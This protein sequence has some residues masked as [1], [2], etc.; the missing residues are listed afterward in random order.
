[1][2]HCACIE[3]LDVLLLES[4][5][6]CVWKITNALQA[7]EGVRLYAQTI[8]C[9]MLCETVTQLRND[10]ISAFRS[11]IALSFNFRRRQSVTL[12][13]EILNN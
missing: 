7:G 13:P 11:L 4:L 8:S 3:V 12:N 5:K 10:E 1:M 2:A 9:F 6:R